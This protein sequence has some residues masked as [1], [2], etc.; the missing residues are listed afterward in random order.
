MRQARKDE[1]KM[2][3]IA[4]RVGRGMSLNEAI[5]QSV[6]ESKRSWALRHWQAYG[7]D[8]WEGLIDGRKG[9][10][11]KLTQACEDMVVAARLA[12]RRLKVEEM[13]EILEDRGVGS[14]PSE[15]MVKRLFARADGRR[16]AARRKQVRGRAE[17]AAVKVEELG[18]AG[19]ELLMAAELE[20]RG[21]AALAEEV[22]ALGA[23]A[24]EESKGQTP[25]RD[26]AQRDSKGRFTAEYNRR[27]RRK[28]GEP[29]A[30]YLRPAA[31][32]GAE[33][34]P[35]WPR[36]VHEQGETIQGKLMML[37]MEPLVSRRPGWN[38]LRAQPV[39]EMEGLVSYVYMPS[40]LAKFTSALAQAQAGERLM[41]RVGECWHAVA[42]KHWGEGGAMAALYVDNHVKAVWTSQ[43]MLSGKVSRVGR[44]MPCLTTSY[45]HTGAGTPVVAVVQ[46]GTAPLAPNFLQMVE[47]TEAQLAEGIRRAVV[48]DAEGSTFDILAACKGQRVI[49]TPLRPGQAEKVELSYTRGSYYRPYRDGG[50]LRVAKVVLRHKSSNRKLELHALLVRRSH[51]DKDTV[52]LTTGIEMGLGGPDLADLYYNRWPLQENAFREGAAVKLDRH[53]GNNRQVVTN[54]AVVT[55]WE[56]NQLRQGVLTERLAQLQAQSPKVAEQANKAQR[57]HQQA[58]RKLQRCRQKMEALE[59]ERRASPAK[60]ARAGVLYHQAVGEAETA[61]KAHVRAEQKQQNNQAR[62]EQAQASLAQLEAEADKLRPLRTIRQLDVSLDT[63]LTAIKLTAAQLIAFVVRM[64]LVAMPM[65]AE[66][67]LSRVLTYKGRREIGIEQERVVFYQNPRDPQV[68]AA[69]VQACQRLNERGLSRAGKRLIYEIRPPPPGSP[70]QNQFG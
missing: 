43:Y 34:V 69:L 65:T 13:L 38:G 59:Q 62:S 49:V 12:N 60:V 15:T 68:N 7:K 70:Q 1:R 21:V 25:R 14:L 32:K 11:P 44:V 40:T 9:R 42:Q 23:E 28:E 19:G 31:D 64:Y 4:R 57:V 8:G 36:F 18:M 33:K 6:P 24:V 45:V 2:K 67:F 10:E 46:S 5:R 3:A 51:R 55:E 26:R 30:R 53:R 61:Q 63:V 16:K 66:T 27:R 58:Q 22:M 48:I 20:T 52:L 29:I 47:D 54:V 56:K 39:A 17:E 41:M 50:Q 37:V 35:S